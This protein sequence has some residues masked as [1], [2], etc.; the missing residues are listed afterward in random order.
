MQRKYILKLYVVGS[1]VASELAM[2]KKDN[3]RLFLIP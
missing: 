3:Y 2:R 1:T